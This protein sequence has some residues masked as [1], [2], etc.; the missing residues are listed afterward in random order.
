VWC[1]Q[2]CPTASIPL[3]DGYRRWEFLLRQ[4]RDPASFLDDDSILRLIALRK[5]QKG[6]KV[7]RRL[8]HTYKGSVAEHYGRG[9]IF[10]AGDAAHLSPPFAGQGLA[11]GLRDAANLAWKLAH[12]VR[13]MDSTDLLSS[14]ESERRPHQIKMLQ[15]ARR[16][17]RMM[18]PRFRIQE[19]LV[20]LCLTIAGRFEGLRRLMEIR[21][22]NIT[23]VYG[24]SK[25]KTRTGH[26]LIQPPIGLNGLLDDMLGRNY[27]IITFDRLAQ[28]MLSEEEFL[29]WEHRD[30]VFLRIC[31][32][33]EMSAAY[34][35]FD[36]W[37]EGC[38]RRLLVVRP[39]R[40][41]KEDRI[42]PKRATF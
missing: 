39:D 15:L 8:V 10:L 38:H 35:A 34:E 30:T 12:V 29:K 14:Y 23:P 5:P 2:R 24:D 36:Q 27:T 4:E 17:G 22:S 18:M 40:F 13:G 6:I 9:R 37:L 20:S 19:I 32:E 3:P 11:T 31:P 21:G 26:Y 1:D 16:M 25:K 7:L 41:V 33:G 42:M 28:E